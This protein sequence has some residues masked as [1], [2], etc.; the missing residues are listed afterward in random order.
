MNKT[1]KNL[2]EIDLGIGIHL[3]P[4]L[5]LVHTIRAFDCNHSTYLTQEFNALSGVTQLHLGEKNE[6]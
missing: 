3:T 2:N 4:I 6:N 1:I 5:G